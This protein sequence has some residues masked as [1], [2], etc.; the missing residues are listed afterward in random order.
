M[1]L[2]RTICAEVVSTNNLLAVYDNSDSLA[3]RVLT[4]GRLNPCLA[5]AFAPGGADRLEAAL[6]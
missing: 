4:T 5:A 6:A 1:S 2:H 3:D